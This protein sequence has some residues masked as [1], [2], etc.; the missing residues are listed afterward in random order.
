MKDI[1]GK[2]KIFKREFYDDINLE[3]KDW[4]IDPE[5]ILKLFHKGYKVQEV[6]VNFGAR[7][8]GKSNVSYFTVSEFMMNIL[9][10]RVALWK[11]RKL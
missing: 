8:K 1:N 7:T 10:W 5:I 6:K 11:N 9:R 2:P 3:C 4:F